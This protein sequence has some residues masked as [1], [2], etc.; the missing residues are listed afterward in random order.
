MRGITPATIALLVSVLALQSAAQPPETVA[1]H[2]R[3]E[4][5]AVEKVRVLPLLPDRPRDDQHLIGETASVA[6]ER[7][8]PTLLCAGARGMAVACDYIAADQ[9]AERTFTLTPGREV[10]F[11]CLVD[12]KPAAGAVVR[13]QRDDVPARTPYALPFAYSAG[14]F[15]DRAIASDA[16]E[17]VISHLAPGTYRLEVELEGHPPYDAGEVFIPP[18]RVGRD[19]S[20]ESRKLALADVVIPTGATVIVDVFDTEGLPVENAGAVIQ[21]ARENSTAHPVLVEG[22]TDRKGRVTFSGLDPLRPSTVTCAAAGYAR[23]T[24][25]LDTLPSIVQCTVEKLANATGTVMNAAGE[26]VV[27]AHVEAGERTGATDE[28]GAFAL[29]NLP[30]RPIDIVV[31]AAGYTQTRRTVHLPAGETTDTG[32]FVLSP[33]WQVTGRVADAATKKP[34]A[35]A[36]VRN[37]HHNNCATTNEEGTY[38]LDGELGATFEVSATGYAVTDRIVA[39]KE[40][41]D[42][43][44]QPPG[45]LIVTVWDDIADRPCVHCP[46]FVGGRRMIRSANTDNTAQARFNG[47][48]PGE[49]DVGRER[50]HAASSYVTVSG[51]NS[52]TASVYPNQTTHVTIGKRDFVDVVFVPPAAG[53]RLRVSASDG[54]EVID[55]LPSGS[56]RT[57]RRREAASLALLTSNSGVLVG[58]IPQGFTGTRWE[59]R[60]H[61]TH[62]IV[63]CVHEGQPAVGVATEVRD[64][65]GR[66]AAWGTSDSRGEVHLAH[67]PPGSYTVRAAG[68]NIPIVIGTTGSA[69]VQAG[70]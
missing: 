40:G 13:L 17:V 37:V 25:K 8:V 65:T 6:V 34:V 42:F 28:N 56:Y 54:F 14:G 2:I 12:R 52:E 41:N 70:Q 60:L 4:G 55:A 51:G 69:V 30:P 35:G 15:V 58:T 49:Y 23:N 20:Q 3:A 19:G 36:V 7:A 16:G 48:T 26:P 47:L 53:E 24:L 62:A 1:I 61:A 18:Q 44:L 31:S 38:Q 5:P 63:R 45:D 66:A 46:I 27:S 32:E 29:K 39:Q 21:Q 64:A 11:R 59:L 68:A 50:V 33:G 43:L 67:V 10:R 9:A 22:G 57:K